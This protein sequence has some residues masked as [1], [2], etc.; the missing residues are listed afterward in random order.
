DWLGELGPYSIFL[1]SLFAFAEACIGIGLLVSGAF[2]VVVATLLYSN[3][4]A[5]LPVIIL[6]ALSGALLGDHAGFYVGR[7]LGP[8]FHDLAIARKYQLSVAKAERLL[9]RWGWL[10]IFIG[11]FVPAIRSLLPALIGISGFGRRRYSLLDFMACMLWSAAL[12]S[13]VLGL[14]YSF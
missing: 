13:I 5:S 6:L 12:G 2:L 14:D 9:H 3:D 4:M 1:V 7:W 11:R 10:A 8:R